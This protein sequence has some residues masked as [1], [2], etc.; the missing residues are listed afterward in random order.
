M[1]VVEGLDGEQIGEQVRLAAEQRSLPLELGATELCPATCA[2][3][4]IFRRRTEPHQVDD[5][6]QGWIGDA[7]AVA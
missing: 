4:V 2:F 7:G 1:P 5:S 6:K 3:L